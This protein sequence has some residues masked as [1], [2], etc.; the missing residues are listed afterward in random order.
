ML[1][2]KIRFSKDDDTTDASGAEDQD[3]KTLLDRTPKKKEEDRAPKKKEEEGRKKKE[4]GKSKGGEV[5][6]DVEVV[7]TKKTSNSSQNTSDDRYVG[8]SISCSVI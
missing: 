6:S 1:K 7:T 2:K 8:I 4:E 5:D 3:G